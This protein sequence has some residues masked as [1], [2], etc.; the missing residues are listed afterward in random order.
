MRGGQG[1]EQRAGNNHTPTALWKAKN[2]L[3]SSF[4]FCD[5]QQLL[6]AYAQKASNELIQFVS[7]AARPTAP[8]RP[9]AQRD[10]RS[11]LRREFVRTGRLRCD[12]PGVLGGCIIGMNESKIGKKGCAH[13]KGEFTTLSGVRWQ[14]NGLTTSYIT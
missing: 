1:R 14:V 3:H 9:I 8:Q 4:K 7:R 6:H 5:I 12:G 11:A 13:G 10:V 2:H